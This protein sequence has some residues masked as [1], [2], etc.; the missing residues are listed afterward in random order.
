M[1]GCAIRRV[2]AVMYAT[3]SRGVYAVHSNFMVLPQKILDIRRRGLRS[4]AHKLGFF[5]IASDWSNKVY[6]AERVRCSWIKKRQNTLVTCICIEDFSV[7][8]QVKVADCSD[9]HQVA[10]QKNRLFLTDTGKNRVLVFD[11]EKR[12]LQQ[13]INLGIERRDKNHINA[14]KVVD[15]QL[16]IGLNNRSESD[17]AIIEIPID[18]IFSEKVIIDGFSLGFYRRINGKSDTHDL[19]PVGNKILCS[20][21]KQGHV[22]DLKTADVIFSGSGWVRGITSDQDY[23]YVGSSPNASR[24]ER[25]TAELSPKITKISKDDF[26]VVNE[27]VLH[28]AGQLNDLLYE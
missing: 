20:A 3:T 26:S 14:I 2:G 27:Q 11:L 9:V 10:L 5:G 13:T 28:S 4:A 18:R 21:S 16:L 25:H 12:C 24:K 17:S 19:E 23:I 22:F 15:D 7:E 1:A 6:V 8:S